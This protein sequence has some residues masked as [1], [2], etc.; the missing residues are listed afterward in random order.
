M[1]KH[2]KPWLLFSKQS[3]SCCIKNR[4]IILKLQLLILYFCLEKWA[5]LESPGYRVFVLCIRQQNQSTLTR[6]MNLEGL[7][8]LYQPPSPDSLS[9]SSRGNS[10]ATGKIK[11]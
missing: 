5:A 10:I 3:V 6:F 7:P 2:W 11:D 9:N 8:D 1:T 4:Q